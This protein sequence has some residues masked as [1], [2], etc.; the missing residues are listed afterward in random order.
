MDPSPHIASHPASRRR[1]YVQLQAGER[2]PEEDFHLSVLVRFQAHSPARQRWVYVR[3]T[4][5][6]ERG[7]RLSFQLFRPYGPLILSGPLPRADA[8]G[9]ILTR[10]RRFEQ[11][12]LKRRE[13]PLGRKLILYFFADRLL[14]AA[15]TNMSVVQGPAVAPYRGS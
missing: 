3:G 15:S 11:Q 2:I 8:L 9:Y 10:L 5:E 7:E 14:Y 4:I 12:P 6:P 1:S 13:C